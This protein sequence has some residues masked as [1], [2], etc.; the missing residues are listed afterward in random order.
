MLYTAAFDA[1]EANARYGFGTLT[2]ATA[3]ETD[4]VLT[5]SSITSADD[6]GTAG[7]TT[8]WVWEDASLHCVDHSPYEQTRYSHFSRKTWAEAIESALQTAATAAGWAA[9]I[10]AVDFSTTTGFYT[11]SVA[12]VT[13]AW[14][15][16][17]ANGRALF[18]FTANS[19]TASTHTSTVT[20]LFI[21]NPTL[22][23]VSDP[24][25]SYEPR[26]IGNRV[27]GDTG[28]GFGNARYVSPL[29]RDWVQ[30]FETKAKSLRLHAASTHPWTFQD[31]HEH[32]RGV[33]PFIVYDGGFEDATT[34]P[35]V[36]AFREEGIP[37]APERA[38]PGNDAQFHHAFKCIVD[39][40]L[41]AV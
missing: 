32:C 4:V 23:S 37:F 13:S 3:G 2:V 11:F 39:G 10:P 38:T 8:F 41:E 35:I 15:W 21:I 18:G 17:T 9:K 28:E 33:Y 14:S 34:D 29:Y 40:T 1:V 24:T 31:L 12:T 26:S 19:S 6:D 25:T 5:L 22:D 7:A 20:P 36:F 16:S 30:Q 27:V